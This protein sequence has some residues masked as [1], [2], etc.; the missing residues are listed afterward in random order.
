MRMCITLTSLV[1]ESRMPPLSGPTEFNSGSDEAYSYSTVV[2]SLLTKK[3]Q[4]PV[5]I[6]SANADGN[7]WFY[8]S[9]IPSAYGGKIWR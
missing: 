2:A 9:I 7:L 8:N 6:R 1:V 4:S 5:F 3:L